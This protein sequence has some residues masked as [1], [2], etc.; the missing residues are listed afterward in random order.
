MSLILLKDKNYRVA[1]L[2][3]KGETATEPSQ[4]AESEETAQSAEETSSKDFSEE[5]L[6]AMAAVPADNVKGSSF[7]QENLCTPEEIRS[8]GKAT[9]SAYGIAYPTAI[10]AIGEI[11]LRGGAP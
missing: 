6:S 11:I 4:P 3:A 8:V 7:T 9:A 1:P 2:Y 5:L 10:R